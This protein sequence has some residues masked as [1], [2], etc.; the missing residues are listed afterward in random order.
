MYYKKWMI[1]A[2]ILSLVML[3][4]V[5]CGSSSKLSKVEK[6]VNKYIDTISDKV[7]DQAAHGG[8]NLF[9]IGEIVD[10][11]SK[12]SDLVN[13]KYPYDENKTYKD[14]MEMDS[15]MTNS[16]I[17]FVVKVPVGD[18]D[19]ELAKKEAGKE[20]KKYY[21]VG[22]FIVNIDLQ[23]MRLSVDKEKA[24]VVAEK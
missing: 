12:N 22:K 24:K 23:S 17:E 7:Y 4:F 5:A 16:G 14:V 21:V 20:G 2:V 6:W 8:V 10:K 19:K 11:V 9:G 13:E 1:F 18:E 3:N 15:N